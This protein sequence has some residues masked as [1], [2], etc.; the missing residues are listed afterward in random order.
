M[1]GWVYKNYSVPAGN[2]DRYIPR[3]FLVGSTLWTSGGIH[4]L[5]SFV[6]WPFVS[7]TEQCYGLHNIGSDAIA[8]TYDGADYHAYITDDTGDTWTETATPT[9]TPIMCAAYDSGYYYAHT[10]KLWC[11]HWG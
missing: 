8:I 6:R 9:G 7:A 10:S 11:E 4:T 1:Y 2:A 3:P 5:E